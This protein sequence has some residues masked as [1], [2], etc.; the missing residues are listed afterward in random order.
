MSNSAV[1]LGRRDLLGGVAALTASALLGCEP[2]PRADLPVGNPESPNVLIL[3][4]D[5]FS[6]LHGAI[7]GYSRD[8]TPNLSVF[9]DR[10]VVYHHNH[11]AGNF[12]TPGTASLLTGTLPWTHRALHYRGWSLKGSERGSLFAHFAGAGYQGIAYSHNTL[13]T[14]LLHA[15]RHSSTELK[16]TR[17]L[18]VVDMQVVERLFPRDYQVAVQRELSL[19][20]DSSSLLGRKVLSLAF[21]LAVGQRWQR[22]YRTSFPRGLPELHWHVYL[23]EHAVDWLQTS[24][25]TWPRPFLGYFH[26][27]PPHDPYPPRGEFVGRFDDEWEAAKK[28]R[29]LFSQGHTDGQLSF[30]RRE[31]DEFIAY[32]DGEF[33]RLIDGLSERGLLDNTFV[34]LTS[35]H[36]E[37]FERGIW[38]HW[39]PVLYE[40]IIRVPL[41]IHAPGQTK[42]VDVH[43]PTSG[44]DLLPTLLHATGHPVPD[45]FEGEVMP[46]FS[47]A[48]ADPERSIYA[49]EAKSNPKYGPLRKGTVALLRGHLKLIR[50]F[51]YDEIDEGYELYDLTDDPDELQDLYPRGGKL[52]DTMREELLDKL[53][54]VN[55]PFLKGR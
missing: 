36:G 51:G 13:V 15:L 10:A 14:T 5:A 33:G 8:T 50:Y 4:F 22:D 43:T 25:P 24:L 27:L 7:Y 21:Q 45:G 3:V 11:A 20:E 41:L 37:L 26:L 28:P 30:K 12:T 29:H 32:A 1:Q 52:A 42:R 18:C 49:V 19:P 17:D 39:T 9:A 23:L 6:A 55:R 54:D 35:D 53:R 38:G 40:P 47:E 2:R 16:P 34:V 46:P 48:A 31:Y 44:V